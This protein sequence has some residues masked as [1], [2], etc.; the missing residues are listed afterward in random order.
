MLDL[1]GLDGVQPLDGPERQQARPQARPR[2]R[3]AEPQP[4]RARVVTPPPIPD[5]EPLGTQAAAPEEIG[6]SELRR[7]PELPVPRLRPRRG[8]VPLVG[9]GVGAAIAIALVVPTRPVETLPAPPATATPKR[10]LP[11]PP[12]LVMPPVP[13]EAVLPARFDFNGLVP[14]GDSAAIAAVAQRCAGAIVLTGHADALGPARV[15][16]EIALRRAD[17]VRAL[18]VERGVDAARVLIT[19]AGATQPIAPNDSARGR[20]D[21]RRVT[22]HCELHN[23]GE[24]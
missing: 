20:R 5:D 22:L 2:G 9:L 19:S 16:H 1:D 4:E 15:N 12:P 3:Q 23:G 11:A 10:E 8:W 14:R 6:L 17:A 7:M 18:L 21:N 13:V 24:P